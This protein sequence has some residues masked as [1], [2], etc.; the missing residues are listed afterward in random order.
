VFEEFCTAKKEGLAAPKRNY[1]EERSD[2]KQPTLGGW[3]G[4]G[5][6]REEFAFH[7][8]WGDRKGERLKDWGMADGWLEEQIL[9]QPVGPK[10]SA[11]R[12]GTKKREGD[13][14]NMQP[15]RPDV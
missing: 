11:Q 15:S 9:P 12:G 2:A 4:L 7:V 14:G 5:T 6:R 3:E 10:L 8:C 13:W 1:T